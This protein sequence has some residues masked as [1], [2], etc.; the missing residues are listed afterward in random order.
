MRG[1]GVGSYERYSGLLVDVVCMSKKGGDLH[2]AMERRAARVR[3][4]GFKKRALLYIINGE[5][6]K[7]GVMQRGCDVLV[8]GNVNIKESTRTL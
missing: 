6:V 1:S 2:L 4:G 7:C 3:K 5:S 8:R